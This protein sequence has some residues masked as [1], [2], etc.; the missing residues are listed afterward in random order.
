MPVPG[1]ATSRVRDFFQPWKGASCPQHSS[2]MD[3]WS[4]RFSGI[5]RLFG[6]AGLDRLRAARVMVVGIGGVGSWVVE[7]LARSGVG[8]LRLVDLDDVCLTNVNRQLQALDG[9][10]GHP[11]VEAMAGRVRGINPGCGVEAV[12]G[13]FTAENADSLLA[14]PLDYVVDAI[15]TARMKALL[16]ARARALGLPVITSG[17]AGGRRDPTRIQVTDLAASTHDHLLAEVRRLLRSAHGFPAAGKPFGVA[18]VVS[19][20]PPVFPAPD[21]TVCATR[22]SGSDLRLDC[23]SGFGTAS[24]VTGTF[25][26]TLAGRVVA[27][28]AALAE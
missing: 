16:V 4:E 12:T 9:A 10:I 24:F 18:C 22:E 3:D 13:F 5:A 2:A 1:T 21:G 7:A 20:E 8:N 28:L 6:T 27:D 14:G 15:D 17:G 25:G 19:T 11:K 26:L 23:H